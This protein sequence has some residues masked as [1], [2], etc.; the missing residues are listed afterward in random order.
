M[1][2]IC[3]Y[4]LSLLAIV[5]SVVAICVSLP[6]TENMSF[7]YQDLIT[8]ILGVL[9][10]VL[11]GWN[12][13]MI[14]DFKQEK[15]KLR[16]YFDEQKKSVNS[17]GADLLVSYRNHLS[18]SALLEKAIADVYAHLLG[19]REYASLAFE[20]LFHL[21]DALASVSKAENY[22]ACSLWVNE[23][24]QVLALASPEQFVISELN[25]QQ[26]LMTLMQVSHTDRF[27]GFNDVVVLIS[28][29]ATIPDS[30]S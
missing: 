13:Y 16:Q 18:N 20:Y 10:T 15:E 5:L 26:L 6:R 9:V 17:V 24:K 8:G 1:K 28:K 27:I 7:D 25:K 30:A 4:I 21:L 12:I 22:D 2:A 3:S 23:I 11:V 19:Q 14:I 29:I